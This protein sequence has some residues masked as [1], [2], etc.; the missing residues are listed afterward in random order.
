[1]RELIERLAN[2]IYQT[3]QKSGISTN[4]NGDWLYAERVIRDI[5]NGDNKLCDWEWAFSKEDYDFLRDELKKLH[6]TAYVALH[7]ALHVLEKIDI[8]LN[9]GRIRE[10]QECL[11]KEAEALRGKMVLEMEYGGIGSG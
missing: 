4:A 2:K 5:L 1:M 6:G 3:E 10:A 11:E 9:E 7:D 8:L